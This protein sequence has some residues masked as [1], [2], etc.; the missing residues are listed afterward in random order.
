[1][2][3]YPFNLPLSE[4]PPLT[5]QMTDTAHLKQAVPIYY[6]HTL[7]QPFCPNLS[8]KC[9]RQQTEV[10]RL[11]N[12]IADGVMAV[13]KVADLIDEKKAEGEI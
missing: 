2:Q 1:M 8:C 3:D 10:K 9:H 5:P 11:L 6:I 13:K 4:Y 7:Q 12:N